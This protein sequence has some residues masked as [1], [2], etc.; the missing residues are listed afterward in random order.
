MK[1]D[2]HTKIAVVAAVLVGLFA[3]VAVNKYIKNRTSVA[4]TPKASILVATMEIKEGSEI[5]EEMLGSAEIPFDSLS[6]M[7]IALPAK[8]D[9]GYQKAFS[10]VLEKI[11]KRKTKR[12]VAAKTPIF[13]IDIET[14]QKK[15]FAD[16]IADGHRAVTVPVDSVSSVCG[17]IRPGS[18]IDVVLTATEEKLGL[19]TGQA[20]KETGSRIVSSVILQNVPVI[21]TDREYDLQSESSGYG[22]MT[23]SL[24]TKAA[25]MMVQARTMGQITYLLR[26]VRDTKTEQDRTNVTV[27][28][29]GSFGETVRSFQ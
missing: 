12:L 28:P 10:D 21:A 29:G 13:W 14:E 15:P 23:L 2:N 8:N 18:R 24:P 9:P 27:A 22:T 19:V 25:I 17:F 1:T 7:H 4:P 20:A 16:L 3:V 11:V 26:N 5:G 6:N